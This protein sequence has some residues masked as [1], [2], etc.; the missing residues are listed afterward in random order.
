MVQNEGP[1]TW[2]IASDNF[3]GTHQDFFGRTS[4]Q[5]D[6]VVGIGVA[7]TGLLVTRSLSHLETL[8][9]KLEAY[10]PPLNTYSKHPT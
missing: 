1:D 5:D 7:S 9:I 8:P 4:L 10:M 6:A 2:R 3:D